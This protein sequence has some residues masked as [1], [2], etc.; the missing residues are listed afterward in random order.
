VTRRRPYGGAVLLALGA[1]TVD[2]ADR[3]LVVA[4]L[5]PASG[6]AL[7]ESARR[8]SVEGADVVEVP[9][10]AAGLHAGV[11]VAV[12][13]EDASQARDVVAAG[14]VLVLDPGGF[15]DAAY[16]EAVRESG[17]TAV[18]AV[19][20]DDAGAVVAALRAVAG[21]ATAVGLDPVRVAVEPVAPAATAV[22]PSAAGLRCV[23]VPVLVSVV[24]TDAAGPDPGAVAGPLSVA[25][26]RGCGL[27]RVAAADVRSA[28]R[29]AD[30]V[31][32]VR[33]G[34]T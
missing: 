24:R 12:R 14:A 3:A 13:T 31:A 30:V 10:H 17:I 18:G 25:V 22:L 16:L 1:S 29:V 27:L 28:R 7:V 2:V 32:A 19:R 26:V 15:A 20:V 11:P 9:A 34:Q 4:V 8:A 33:R 21:R 6:D 5:A 23:G